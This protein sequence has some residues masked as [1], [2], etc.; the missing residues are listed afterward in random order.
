MYHYANKPAQSVSRV[1]QV[2][3]DNFASSK[4]HSMIESFVTH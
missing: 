1:R 3:Y 2:V 4:S